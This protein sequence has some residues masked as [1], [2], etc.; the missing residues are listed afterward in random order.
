MAVEIE[1]KFL[2]KDDFPFHLLK[3]GEEYIQGYLSDV[4][5][6]TIRVRIVGEKGYLTI[7]G[8]TVHASRLEFEYE[9][10][11]DEAQSLL[12]MSVSAPIHK[13]RYRIAF[14]AHV[15]EIDVF[16]GKNEGLMVAEV[17]LTS[18]D[19]V[20]EFPCWIG[21]EVTEDV[22]YYNSNLSIFPYS[23]W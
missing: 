17:E 6:R 18:E 4:P 22:R 3:N 10:P 1:K 11:L 20:I 7:K 9:V 21:K 14:A 16:H 12:S 15:W 19:D 5:E 8:K 13:T 2:L 23:E